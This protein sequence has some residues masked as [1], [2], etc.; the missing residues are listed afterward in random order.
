MRALENK[1][2]SNTN[3]LENIFDETLLHPPNHKEKEYFYPEELKKYKEYEDYFFKHEQK[4]DKK[5]T[6]QFQGNARS[7]DALDPLFR[8]KINAES[9]SELYVTNPEAGQSQHSKVGW[10]SNSF[11]LFIFYLF[12][13]VFNK[14][15]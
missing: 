6:Y 8:G 2:K 10:K 12:I 15:N 1:I 14:I 13:Y 5:R 4:N 3:K 11:Y 7:S 9:T